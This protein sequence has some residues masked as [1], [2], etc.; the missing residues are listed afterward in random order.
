MYDES[1]KTGR[2]DVTTE[3]WSPKGA[4]GLTGWSSG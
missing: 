3:S 2:E 1:V 4:R